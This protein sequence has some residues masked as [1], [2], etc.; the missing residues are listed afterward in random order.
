MFFFVVHNFYPSM[1]HLSEVCGLP[2]TLAKNTSNILRTYFTSFSPEKRVTKR[3]SLKS[4][5]KCFNLPSKVGNLSLS[6]TS[7]SET[8]SIKSKSG[9]A[10][11]VLNLKTTLSDSALID[12]GKCP[13]LPV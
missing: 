5:V 9:S 4:L 1:Q 2:A 11:V 8:E 6:S 13:Y 12:V 3:L 7:H 10:Q